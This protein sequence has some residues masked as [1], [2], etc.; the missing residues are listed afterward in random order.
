MVEVV[1]RMAQIGNDNAH[2]GRPWKAAIDRALALRD[3]R[4]VVD[5]AQALDVLAEKL[6]LAAEEGESWAIKELGDRFD[7]RSAQ[8]VT[9]KGDE[10]E[11]VVTKVIR[12]IVH[13]KNSDS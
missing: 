6:L 11:P 4:G 13:S 3:K 2:K 8:S 10:N 12:E 1:T 7:G 5:Q 9:L